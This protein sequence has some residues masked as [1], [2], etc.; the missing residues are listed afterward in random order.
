MKYELTWILWT[1]RCTERLKVCHA[2]GTAYSKRMVQFATT[3]FTVF[4]EFMPLCH[5]VLKSTHVLPPTAEDFINFINSCFMFPSYRPSSG[6]SMRGFKTQIKMRTYILYMWDRTNCTVVY[7]WTRS[8]FLIYILTYF[9]IMSKFKHCRLKFVI[10]HKFKIYVHLIVSFT[11]MYLMHV[12][13]QY[14]RNM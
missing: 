10:S 7:I 12:D 3:S 2:T 6:S 8:F 11:I 1:E 4:V 13:R 5:I 9:G 14:D